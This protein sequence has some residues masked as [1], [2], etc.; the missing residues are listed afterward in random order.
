M[1]KFV[2]GKRKTIVTQNAT[3][4]SR[5]IMLVILYRLQCSSSGAAVVK[6][7]TDHTNKSTQEKHFY[8]I[9]L[10]NGSENDFPV[11]RP[12]VIINSKMIQENA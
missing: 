5:Q 10:N 12:C 7:L 11:I 9:I 6:S 8:Q 4:G 1:R 3:Y 2:E